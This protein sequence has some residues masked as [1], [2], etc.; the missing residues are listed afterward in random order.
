MSR[1]LIKNAWL[2][3]GVAICICAGISGLAAGR[4]TAPPAYHPGN[5]TIDQFQELE[6]QPENNYMHSPGPVRITMEDALTG[7]KTVLIADDAEG[8]PS[9]DI[10]V[11]GNIR[12]EK[13][14]GALTG[15]SLLWHNT[16]QSG[17]VLDART[18]ISQIDL[19]GKKIEI[20][21]DHSLKAYDASFTTCTLIHP[22]YH[23]TAR[24][25][26]ISSDRKVKA[27]NI[28]FYLGRS[29]VFVLPYFER[30]FKHSVSNPL[31]LPSYSK[32]GSISIRLNNDLITEPSRTFMYDLSLSIR[33]A[34]QGIVAYEQDII[35]S[36][37][38][39]H[40][41]QAQR[42]TAANPLRSAL[43]LTPGMLADPNNSPDM[44]PRNTLYGLLSAGIYVNNRR[45][46]DLRV[47]RLPEIGI[48]ARNIMHRTIIDP[49]DPNMHSKVPNVFGIGFFQPSNWLINADASVGYFQERPT[50]TEQTRMGFRMDA[51]SP[52]FMIKNPLYVR[53]GATVWSNYYSNG[54]AY[55]LL[56]PEVEMDYLLRSNTMINV[57]YRIQQDFG[58]TPFLFD[59]KDVAHEVRLG[60]GFLGARW[61]YDMG[62]HYDVQ[63]WRAYDSSYAIRRRFDCMEIGVAYHTRSQSF[64]FILNLLPGTLDGINGSKK[65]GNPS[66]R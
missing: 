4:P 17:T 48:S 47:S 33:R 64:N 58:R 52:I 11:H 49:A 2:L 5:I 37:P 32:E 16:T 13:Q 40:P 41:P 62:L 26:R 12:L 34:P 9:G 46:T 18:S 23:I 50:H 42:D 38:N 66:A 30:S 36:D 31:P 3:A 63:R 14:Q 15:R 60:Y 51:T 57:A 25:V 20:L 59:R 8:S 44:T 24:D 56:A 61:A 65:P 6:W 19:R 29:K 27:H 43:E 55:T 45:R 28:T 22:D 54:N 21:P 35:P 10:T 53:Y 39:R 1:I 7:E